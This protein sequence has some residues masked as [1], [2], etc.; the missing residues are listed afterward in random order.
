MIQYQEALATILDNVRKMESEEKLLLQAQGQVLAEDI[1][2]PCD[3][4]R[5]A[6]GIPDG[7]AVRS[8][9]I[10][11]ASK[12]HPVTLR[13]VETIRAGQVPRKA[14][15]PGTAVRT[16]TGSVTPE[17]GDCIVRFEDTDEP[18]DKNGPNLFNPTHVKVFA[19]V[20]AGSG[21]T[22][23]GALVK[24][25]TLVVPKGTVIG[26]PQ[27]SVISQFGRVKVKV[28]RRPVIAILSSGDELVKPGRPLSPGK[29]YD[30]N[31]GA[32]ATFVRYYG[33][34]P[35]ILGIARDNEASLADKI[36]KGMKADAIISSGGVS[37]GDYDLTRLII[38]KLGTLFFSRINMAPGA[39]VAFGLLPGKD[40]GKLTPLFALAGP[41]AGSMVNFETLVRP[42]L[43][44]MLGREDVTRPSIEAMP[45][46]ALPEKNN[47]AFVKWTKM[48]KTGKGHQ[49]AF[50]S[51]A[52]GI[53]SNLAAANSLTII[54][55]QTAVDAENPIEVLPLNWC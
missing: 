25:G 44:K 19:P 43:L 30:C 21:I 32:L 28:V 20:A 22:Q 45:T 1:V 4:P 55:P 2:A 29:I 49:V 10:Q 6:T 16:M 37:K 5:L 39:A 17:G 15:Q 38:A 8:E 9:D 54:P 27:V 48:N 46:G 33:G 40:S 52:K 31:S 3:L 18:G 36:T 12:E 41:P 23:P 11:G 7:Y 35:K 26:P 24:Q 34:I 13:I 51:G 14:V 53:L 50:D 47:M 42:A